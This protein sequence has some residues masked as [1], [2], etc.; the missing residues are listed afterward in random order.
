MEWRKTSLMTR[1]AVR[2]VA[3]EEILRQEEIARQIRS[4]PDRPKTYHLITYGC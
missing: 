2:P 3:R 1:D 4:R